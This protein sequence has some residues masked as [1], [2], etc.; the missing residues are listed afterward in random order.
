MK[1]NQATIV[2]FL[3][4]TVVASAATHEEMKD[5]I[6]SL[7]VA[8]KLHRMLEFSNECIAHTEALFDSMLM[9]VESVMDACP[10]ANTQYGNTMIIDY[11]VCDPEF[12]NSLTEACNTA[13]GKLTKY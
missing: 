12:T 9:N 3:S 2:A 5:K 7:L 8:P 13:N 10:E 6:A 4:A 1:L 11:S